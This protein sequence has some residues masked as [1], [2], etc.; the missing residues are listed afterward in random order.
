MTRKLIEW[1]RRILGRES[2]MQEPDAAML[3]CESVMRRLWDYL[4]EE[5][6]PEHMERIRRH[7]EM[8]AQCHP[9]FEF[10]QAFLAAVHRTRPRHSD[11]DALRGR[12]LAALGERG[13][14]DA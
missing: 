7:V 13:L 3:D 9:Q 1:I 12:L 11:L 10:E 5:L 14:R 4:D 2:A 8:C 6:T